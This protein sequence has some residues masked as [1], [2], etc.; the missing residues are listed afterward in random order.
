MSKRLNELKST[1]QSTELSPRPK[2]QTGMSPN[3]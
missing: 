1:V 2:Q 3:Q